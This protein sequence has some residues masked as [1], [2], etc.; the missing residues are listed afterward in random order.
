[1]RFNLH[2]ICRPP[3]THFRGCIIYYSTAAMFHYVFSG[4][5][6][7]YDIHKEHVQ[8]HMQTRTDERH[9]LCEDVF[10]AS[11]DDVA[12]DPIVLPLLARLNER[13]HSETMAQ[14]VPH[15]LSC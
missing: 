12:D 11:V 13:C 4:L 15:T 6:P 3:Q 2:S 8:I 9:P 5:L 10:V 1:M 7:A 14:H